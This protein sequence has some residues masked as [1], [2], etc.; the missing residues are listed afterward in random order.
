MFHG[1]ERKNKK[2]PTALENKNVQAIK[3]LHLSTWQQTK[4][5]C[6]VRQKENIYPGLPGLQGRSEEEKKSCI[7]SEDGQIRDSRPLKKGH[8]CYQSNKQ[9]VSI[10]NQK[11]PSSKF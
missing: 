2:T 11:F 8:G 4:A 1:E 3:E 5:N 7:L 6:Q 10:L 9:N